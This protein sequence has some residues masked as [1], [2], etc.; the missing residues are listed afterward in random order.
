MLIENSYIQIDQYPFLESL[1]EF[2]KLDFIINE[3]QQYYPKTIPV[4]MIN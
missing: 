1:N 3:N 2:T 4:N